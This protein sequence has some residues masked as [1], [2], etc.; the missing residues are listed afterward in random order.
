MMPAWPP[1]KSEEAARQGQG[2]KRDGLVGIPSPRQKI[3]ALVEM[4]KWVVAAQPET[5]AVACS[6]EHVGPGWQ[7]GFKPVLRCHQLRN[8]P[9]RP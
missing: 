4:Y 9:I 5:V 6:K 8:C 1:S 7:W 3:C 2:F